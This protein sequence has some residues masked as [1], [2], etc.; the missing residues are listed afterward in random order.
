MA[1]GVVDGTL[2]G[3][4][5]A[6]LAADL[7]ALTVQYLAPTTQTIPITQTAVTLT[8]YAICQ[9]IDA[10]PAVLPFFNVSDPSVTQ[11]GI[12]NDGAMLPTSRQGRLSFVAATTAP[13]APVGGYIVA[14]YTLQIADG[15]RDLSSVIVSRVANVFFPTIPTLVKG[16]LLREIV[17]ATTGMYTSGPDAAIIE[18]EQV[19]GGA[20]G[21][22]VPGNATNYVSVGS[23][24]GAGGYARYW[25]A[26]VI[27]GLVTIGAGGS[28]TASGE[29]ANA[30]GATT[31]C[32]LVSTAGGAANT[33]GPSI[34]PGTS[35]QVGQ[36]PGGAVSVLN[37]TAVTMVASYDGENAA[38]SYVFNN[39]PS[40]PGIAVSA[41]GAGGPFG[42][43][44]ANT[45]GSDGNPGRGYG[46]GG[47]GAASTDGSPHAGGAGMGGLVIVREWSGVMLS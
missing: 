44:G 41:L 12:G 24:G 28:K 30:G 6:G 13:A 20:S 32:S 10:E 16:R 7:T 34:A 14:L 47:A 3:G 46:S 26:P 25:C 33:V 23:S 8:V 9:E 5:G 36:G 4:N 27:N 37:A 35:A 42:T 45:N 39:G 40:A 43:G 22:G 15:V 21:A 19:G 11:A 31:F 18:V 29:G 38:C 17:M 1:P 2:F